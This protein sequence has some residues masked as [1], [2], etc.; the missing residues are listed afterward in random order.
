MDAWQDGVTFGLALLGSVLGVINAFYAS[1]DRRVRLRVGYS[2]HSLAGGP[3]FIV[4]SVVNLSAFEVTLTTVGVRLK[5][6]G[7]VFA[8]HPWGE[9]IPPLPCRLAPRAEATYKPPSAKVDGQA[10]DVIRVFAKTA[11]D[12]EVMWPPLRSWRRLWLKARW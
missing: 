7:Q 8:D 6:G 4:I 11:C 5:T 2:R 9:D 10:H 12:T 3:E 1:L